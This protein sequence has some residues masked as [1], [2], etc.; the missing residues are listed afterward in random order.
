MLEKALR[1]VTLRLKNRWPLIL[2]GA[3][4]FLVRVNRFGYV[5]VEI[6]LAIALFVLMILWPKTKYEDWE[7]PTQQ[8]LGPPETTIDL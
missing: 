7:R 3:V 2:V 6:Q 5:R 1:Y 8:D 4:I